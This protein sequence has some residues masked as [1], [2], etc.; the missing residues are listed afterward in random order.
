MPEGFLSS[1]EYD[2][3][4]HRLYNDGDY[5]A[6]LE[7][8]KEGLALY[9]NAVELYVGMGYARLAREEYAWAR[10][11][12]ER[13]AVLDPAH[14][15]ALVGLGETLLRFGERETALRHFRQVAE[16]GFDDDIE[17][18]LTMGRA[19]YRA[20]M[21]GD[22]RDIFAKAAA[23]RPDSAEAAAS[24]GYALHRL[25]DDVGAGRQIR[26]ALRLDADLYEARVYLGHLLYDRGDWEG[27]LREFERVPP[28]EHW[29]PLAVWRLMELKRTLWHMESGD[30]RLTPWESR[31]RDLEELDDPIDRLLADVEARMG[32]HDPDGYF[33]PSQLELFEAAAKEDEERV[34]RTADGYLL[35]GD[36]HEIVRQMRDQAGFRHESVSDYMRRMAE[37]WH[38]E[39]GI[40]VPFVDPEAFLRAAVEAGLIRLEVEE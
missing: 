34:I 37:R 21:Y 5:D 15:D 33:D 20:A 13:A 30:P 29:D 31:L 28:Q 16:M 2:E 3:Q 6:A 26:R 36:W 22:C 9:P 39:F 18:M 19:L 38:E 14:E 25:G 1:E 40:E 4:A 7:M 24:L 10:H 32:A 11:A 27:S 12:F 23:S 8:L 35:R 17:L